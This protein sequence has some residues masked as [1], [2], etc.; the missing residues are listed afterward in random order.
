MERDCSG[1]ME[2]CMVSR[3]FEITVDG[4]AVESGQISFPLLGKILKGIQD[5]VYYLALADLQYDY[6][7]RIRVPQDVKQA[8]AIYR[9]VETKGSYRLIAEM[10]PSQQVG[11]VDDLG[12]AAKEK[13]I[14]VL[15]CLKQ[16]A[17]DRLYQILP[18]S[19]Y[20]RKVLRTIASYCPKSGEKWNIGIGKPGQEIVA[21]KPDLAKT[22]RGVLVKP[23]F[24]QM[25]IIGELVQLHLDENKLGLFYAPANKVIHCTYDPELEDFIVSN[26]RELIQVH[27]QVQMDGSGIP[28]KIVDVL[29]IEEVDLT[30][31]VLSELHVEGI[32]LALTEELTISVGF[33]RESQ[34]FTLEHPE[35]NIIVGAENREELVAEY[36]SDFFWLWREYGQGDPLM[37][38]ADGQRL[39]DVM[40]ALVKKESRP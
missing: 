12:L 15:S 16:N 2:F 33:D 3:Q 25:M 20:R 21:L 17:L 24:E 35:L 23:A 29:E 14:E 8:C 4:L 40:R 19:S 7:L 9:V 28:G 22:I 5:T 6:R 39:R 18:D 31:V 32:T 38:S 10:A 36:C 27:G 37:M 13:Y 34:E 1:K 30:P 26:L 11:R